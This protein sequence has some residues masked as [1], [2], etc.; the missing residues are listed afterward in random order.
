MWQENG[1]TQMMGLGLHETG[2]PKW[3]EL[4]CGQNDVIKNY[5]FINK[6]TDQECLQVGE[7]PAKL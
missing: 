1:L 5:R 3:L 7:A 2:R 4:F 6:L